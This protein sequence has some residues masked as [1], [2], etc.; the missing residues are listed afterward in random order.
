M[1]RQD[2]Q[3]LAEIRVQ[4]ALVLLNNGRYAAAYYLCGYAVECAL[5]ACIAKQTMQYEFPDLVRV[6]ESYTHD[7]KNL[8]KWANV[9]DDLDAKVHA[10]AAFEV[11]WSTLSHWSEQTRYDHGITQQDAQELYEAVTDSTDGVLTWLTNFW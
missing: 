3:T 8:I 11:N 1:N 2:F 7:F 5:K 6:R 10:N 9:M 4:D